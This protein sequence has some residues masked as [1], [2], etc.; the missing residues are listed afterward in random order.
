MCYK[1][2]YKEVDLSVDIPNT[3]RI[4]CVVFGII[5][6]IEY[7]TILMEEKVIDIT[8]N[9]PPKCMYAISKLTQQIHGLR[10]QWLNGEISC[11]F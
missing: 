8:K 5:S 6:Y 7:Y 11:D 9:F 10:S 4:T 3:K 2:I 1:Q